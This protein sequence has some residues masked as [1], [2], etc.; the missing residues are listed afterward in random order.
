MPKSDK[1]PGAV[2]KS[3]LDAYQ[4]T[5]AKVA[6]DIKLS[7]SSVRLL[8]NSKLKISI[9][10]ALRLAK[11][12]GTKPEFWIDLQNAYE[13]SEA[14]KNPKEAKI[15]KG[16]QKAKKPAPGAKKAVAKK[17]AAKKTTAKKAPARKAAGARTAKKT[18]RTAKK[19][20]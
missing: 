11:Y 17:A 10:F 5:P 19:G 14:A 12:F 13:L 7:Q 15:V 16:I 20:R 3:F 4:L 8:I 18:V 1:T 9:P 6:E 2:F